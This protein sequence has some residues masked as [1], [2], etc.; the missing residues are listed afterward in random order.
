MTITVRLTG[1]DRVMRRFAGIARRRRT[2]VG[3]AVRSGLADLAAAARSEVEN[4][5]PA[6]GIDTTAL[7]ASIHATSNDDGLGGS[8]GTELASGA[9]LEFGTTT[10]PARPWL[11]PNFARHKPAIRKRIIEA[12]NRGIRGA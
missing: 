3:D 12:V 4:S 1:L 7:A 8:V 2:E 10:T 6:P 5:G 11:Q 9:A